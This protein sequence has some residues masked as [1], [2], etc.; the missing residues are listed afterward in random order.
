MEPFVHDAV[1]DMHMARAELMSALG[2]VGVRDWMRYVP[3][4]SRTLHDLL[5]HVAGADQAWALAAQGLLRGEGEVA[6]PLPPAEAK[7]ARERTIDRGR[8]RGTAELLEEMEQR[9]KLLLGLYDLLEP[10]H[11]ALALR[12]YGEQHNSV[13]ERIWLGYH[14]RLHAADVRRAMRLTWAPRKLKLLPQVQPAADALAADATLYV[15]HNVDPVNW[16]RP[17]PLPGWSYRQL[18]TH[19]ATGDWVLQG[20]LRQIIEH[21]TVGPWPDVDAGNAQRLDERAHSTDRALTE[22]FLSMRHETMVLFSH[23]KPKHLEIAIEYWWE[24]RPNGHAILEYVLMFEKHDRTHR[25]QLR[26]AMRW[27]RAYGGYQ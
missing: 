25:E 9:R 22:E 23:L 18:L 16:E 6:S 10:R 19:I 11:L 21:D 5:A 2:D 26:P 8:G 13:R 12:S 7:A 20:Q 1:L 15:I 24:P 4:G 27:M 3:Y 17:S 14:D